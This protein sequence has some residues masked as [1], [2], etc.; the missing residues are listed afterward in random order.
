MIRRE[1]WS[2]MPSPR[3]IQA[4][5]K[6]AAR[7]TCGKPFCVKGIHRE[8]RNV[9]MFHL[10]VLQ[11][12]MKSRKNQLTLAKSATKKCL[13]KPAKKCLLKVFSLSQSSI[14]AAV[15]TRARDGSVIGGSLAVGSTDEVLPGQ[16]VAG[17]GTALE[18]AVQISGDET[19]QQEGEGGSNDLHGDSLKRSV[20]F[21]TQKKH[22]LLVTKGLL[23][24]IYWKVSDG[25]IPVQKKD[26]SKGSNKMDRNLVIS[27]STD[28][29][30]E[31]ELSL[32]LVESTSPSTEK[33]TALLP[34]Y[35]PRELIR[36][37]TT[38][39]VMR[40]GLADRALWS[41][42]AVSARNLCAEMIFVDEMNARLGTGKL[43]FQRR[44][45][46]HY[47]DL[48]HPFH[49]HPCLPAVGNYPLSVM[50]VLLSPG[51]E[52]EFRSTDTFGTA[53][54]AIAFD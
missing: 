54:E 52:Q 23:R 35:D 6:P 28:S 40:R 43:L 37:P 19:G 29:S 33:N 9:A 8:L 22:E 47:G 21:R 14:R 51:L 41:T 34:S 16:D 10:L 32:A 36:S 26:C 44:D 11:A 24:R 2:P 7:D 15:S 39:W 5:K 31:G 1:V 46:G 38:D 53:M 50:G 3:V 42:I 45:Q 13:L 4:R 25:R 27:T 17:Q 20:V 12:P 49:D 48:H 18:G 30:G